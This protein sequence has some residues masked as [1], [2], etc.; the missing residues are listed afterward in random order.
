LLCACADSEP[1]IPQVILHLHIKLKGKRVPEPGEFG[2]FVE[3]EPKNHQRIKPLFKLKESKFFQKKYTK[4][5]PF[6]SKESFS[7]LRPP[8]P[9][10]DGNPLLPGG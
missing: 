5:L 7:S 9:P 8:E 10:D 3:I 2:K 1:I 4:K 6:I